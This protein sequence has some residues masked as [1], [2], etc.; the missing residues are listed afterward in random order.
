MGRPQVFLA[1]QTGPRLNPPSSD[2]FNPEHGLLPPAPAAAQGQQG[3]RA[4][5][6]ARPPLAA[7]WGR[8][9]WGKEGGSGQTLPVREEAKGHLSHQTSRRANEG[10][11]GS[12]THRMEKTRPPHDTTPVQFTKSP[13][14]LYQVCAR[15]VWAGRCDPVPGEQ[16]LEPPHPKAHGEPPRGHRGRGA[17]ADLCA[18]GGIPPPRNDV[19]ARSNTD[20]PR[21]LRTSYR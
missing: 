5:L 7:P 8:K 12:L 14:S 15:P 10:S 6:S 19:L 4:Q 21:G 20:G 11:Q 1:H 16:H 17:C 2:R 3:P 18:V 13:R 9:A